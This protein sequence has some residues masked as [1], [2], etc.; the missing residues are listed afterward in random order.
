MTPKRPTRPLSAR[1]FH[2]SLLAALALLFAGC[3]R[4][5]EPLVKEARARSRPD[6]VPAA[7][8]SESTASDEVASPFLP[9][10][11]SSRAAPSAPPKGM[12]WI[13]GG[14]F[15]MG[16][17]DPTRGGH[18]HEPM[19][20]A[21]PIHRVAI[22]GYFIDQ[23]E[24]TNRAFAEFVKATGHVTLAERPPRA[25]ELPGVPPELLV[26]GS[27][28][29]SPT[30]APTALDNPVRWWRYVRGADWRHPEGPD[31]A[32]VGREEHP[33]VHVGFEDAL[34]YAA[35]LGHDLPTEAEW[36][37]AARGGLSGALYAWGNELTP[38]GDHRANT[39]QGT[40]PVAD[41]AEDG[42]VGSAPVASFEPNAYGI[43][44]VAGNV[45]EWTRDWYDAA[46]YGRRGALSVD[47]SGPERGHD[48]SE[49]SV[50]KRVIRGGSFLCTN[51][52]CT[53]YMVGTRGKADPRSPTAH[54]GFRTVLRA[55]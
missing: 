35:W 27:N 49:P 48:P 39:Y 40:F 45:W 29:F 55:R 7:G 13:A 9:T 50:Q 1:L 47:P 8:H 14:E 33:V 32:L 20:D 51:A 12:V 10:R 36:E 26:A 21:R 37:F 25:E 6:A 11:A 3:D 23:T 2:P 44:D 52:Y 19:D 24:V 18:C 15:S 38:G 22:G 46:E 54:V 31:S 4:P 17:A 16:S 30:K 5:A 34:A 43:Y 28:V 42:F 53:R 41:T